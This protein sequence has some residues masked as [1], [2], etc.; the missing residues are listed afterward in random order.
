MFHVEQN[1][2][3]EFKAYNKCLKQ[4]NRALREKMSA[5]EI[6]VWDESLSKHGENI[7]RMRERHISEIRRP[8]EEM[9]RLF[10]GKESKIEFKKGFFFQIWV[11]DFLNSAN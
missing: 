11:N 9:S 4:R 1:Y 8:F 3:S 5:K 2:L 7:T 10:I 6:G